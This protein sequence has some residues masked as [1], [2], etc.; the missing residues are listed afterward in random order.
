MENVNSYNSINDIR[1]RKEMLR[2]DILKDNQK[3]EKLWKSLF[4]PSEA[5]SRKAT[6]AQR[7][8]G[9][10]NTSAGILDGLILGWKLYRKFKK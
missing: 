8:S 3:I 2:N 6:P 10:L 4:T 9:L 5:F 1:L 7:F